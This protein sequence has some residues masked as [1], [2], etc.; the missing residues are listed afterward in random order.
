MSIQ[1]EAERL[2]EGPKRG[3][4]MLK[5]LRWLAEDRSRT[6][7]LPDDEAGVSELAQAIG[8]SVQVTRALIAWADGELPDE[9]TLRILT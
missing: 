7:P 4:V 8:Q 5:I 3:R 9:D 6:L 1:D 2:A